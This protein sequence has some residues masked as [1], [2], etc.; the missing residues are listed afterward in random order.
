[1]TVP[2][3]VLLLGA[4]SEIGMAIV[5]A[6]PLPTGSDVIL[7][8]RDRAAVEA[9]AGTL[10]PGVTSIVEEFDAL[11]PDT[12]TDVLDTAFARGAVD[13]AIPAF[14]VLG[15]QQLFEQRPAEADPLLTVNV[16]AQIRALLELGR[17]LRMQGN[18]TIVVLSS[19]ASVRPRRANFVYGASKVA[20]DSAARGLADSLSETDVRV[21]L[22]R[23]GFVIGRMTR[24]MRPAPLATTPAAVAD[25]VTS[26]LAARRRTIWVPPALR[27]LAVLLRMVPGPL[28]RRLRR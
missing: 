16:V 24:G 26:A 21:L 10:P 17:R 15:D 28:W 2:V 14:G 4:T 11:H 27:Y 20:L 6:L 18:G 23:P 19:V 3:R 1:M 22:V 7:A 9:V 13:V 25:A 12:V 8:G 5:N